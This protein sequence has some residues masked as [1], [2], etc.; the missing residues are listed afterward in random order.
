MPAAG[1]V[2][3]VT[4]TG[5]RPKLLDAAAWCVAGQLFRHYEWLILD[6]GE[7]PHPTLSRVTDPRIRYWHTDVRQSIGA[8]RNWLIERA[9]GDIIVHFDDDDFYGP[10]YLTRMLA[11]MAAN[12]ADF[13]KLFDMFVYASELDVFAYWDLVLRRTP[14]FAICGNS[15]EI[16]AASAMTSP[17][18]LLMP[19]GYGCTYVFRKSVWNK[20][21]FP[22]R[23]WGEDS[24]FFSAAQAHCSFV[25]L[26]DDTMNFIKMQHA[27]NTSRIF[28]QAI[29][30]EFMVRKT[31]P[32]FLTYRRASIGR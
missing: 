12:K 19:Y 22:D 13:V 8:K 9:R 7:A 21:P 20:A 10:Q 5:N 24:A 6:D 3:I 27:S 25:G 1:L 14:Q 31:A 28:P 17:E 4:P 23:D 30:P 18:W 29:I 2:S 16:I 26:H 32:A 11:A 15:I